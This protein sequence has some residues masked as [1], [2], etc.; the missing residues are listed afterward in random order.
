MQKAK[1]QTKTGNDMRIE[2]GMLYIGGVE[3]CSINDRRSYD[4]LKINT[5]KQFGSCRFQPN[6]IRPYG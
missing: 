4:G 2:N 6:T 3:E 1:R 5:R